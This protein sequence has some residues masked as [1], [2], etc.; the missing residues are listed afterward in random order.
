MAQRIRPAENRARSRSRASR[1]F[2]ACFPVLMALWVLLILYPNPVRLA[3]SVRRLATPKVDTAAVET[4]AASLPSDP[5]AIEEAILDD[6]PYE[7]D[8]EVYDMPWYYPTVAEALENGQGDCKAR[9]I[10][11]ASVLEAKGIPYRIKSSPMHVWVD[12]DGK[13][14][15]TTEDPEAGF[16]EVDPQTGARSLRLPGIDLA[17][18]ADVFWQGFWPPMPVERKVLLISG[19]VI[20]L[21]LRIAW[22]RMRRPAAAGLSRSYAPRP[23]LRT[24]T[25]RGK[26]HGEQGACLQRTET[27]PGGAD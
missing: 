4:L 26:S 20:L 9:A 8:W 25:N 3:V 21:A 13:G 10:V 12:Y 16:Y 6:I 18:F 7:Y 15:S 11:L 1:I 23:V 19:L 17:E 27:T 5:S 22:P 14:E 24:W 2:C